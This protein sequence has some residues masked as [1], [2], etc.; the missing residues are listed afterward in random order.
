[1]S[2]KKYTLGIDFGT[3]S[4]R[5]VLMEVGTGKEIVTSIYPYAN[6]VIDKKLPVITRPSNLRFWQPGREDRLF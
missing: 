2:E 5:A 3:E 6:G 4:G 1:M